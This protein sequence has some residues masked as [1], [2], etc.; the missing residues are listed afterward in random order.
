MNIFLFISCTN[1]SKDASGSGP[2]SDTVFEDS[3]NIQ[4]DSGD[5]DDSSETGIDPE[6]PSIVFSDAFFKST[7]NSYSGE[8]RGSITEQLNEGIRGLEFDI[9]DNDFE[10]IGDY[11]LG[12]YSHD[13]E[14]SLGN[15]N[16][17]TT[18]LTDWL[19]IVAQWSIQN[20]T[21][22]PITLTLDIK[23][24]FTD[25]I[26]FDNGN[27]AKLNNTLVETI[28]TKL[29]TPGDLNEEWPTIEDLSGRILIVLS[30][31]EESRQLYKRDRGYNPA[32]AIN[33]SGTVIEVHDS[34]SG[35]LWY[36]TGQM[37]SQGQVEWK[38]HGQY[39]TGQTPS[40]ALNNDG[41]FVEVHQSESNPSL[42]SRV[43]YIDSNYVPIFNDSEEFDSGV[44]PTIRFTDKSGFELREIHQSQNTG[45][46][47]DWGLVV[48]PNTSAISWGSHEQT[49]DQLHDKDRDTASMW[50][51][52]DT[53][54]HQTAGNDTLL[55]NTVL[56]THRI[57]FPQVAFI[58]YQI[59]NSS[60]L[61]DS[62]TRFSAIGSG[63]METIERWHNT[64]LITRLWGFSETDSGT[65][66]SPPNFPATDHPFNDW[67][68]NYCESI[69]TTQ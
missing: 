19:L 30:G 31:N 25:N 24:D 13:A 67:Y 46:H 11:R 53:N 35:T 8:E 6:E 36:W 50:I 18:L 65:I 12:H 29:F 2:V 63:N 26:N 39:D 9:H 56:G 42:W 41:W 61:L 33:E 66:S 51:E 69:V 58:E 64:G 43:G 54:S 10:Q 48:N 38:H 14:V 22:A 4:E 47:W 1:N 15:G 62:E 28:G 52:V 5:L 59:N 40:I 44:L 27:M 45:L 57:R 68:E 17:Q 21:H 55:V 32:V 60:E 7:H 34:G 3:G 49:N 23:D 20:P 16:P 37:T